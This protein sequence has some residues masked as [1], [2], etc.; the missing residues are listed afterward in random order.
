MSKNIKQPWFR[1]H[2]ELL[3]DVEHALKHYKWLRLVVKEDVVYVKGTLLVVN[4]R[5]SIEISFP[6]DYPNT[7]PVVRETGGKIP[8]LVD[9]HVNENN[10]TAC[11]CV[12][13][14]WF[15]D[16]TDSSF[17]TFLKIPVN[18]YFLSQQH[19]E[20]HKKWPFDERKHG[21]EGI[22][23][24]YKEHFATD[25]LDVIKKYL[26]YLSQNTIKGHW[27]CPC[28]SGK[29]LRKCHNLKI[30]KMKEKLPASAASKSLQSLFGS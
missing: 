7:L 3:Q 15:I 16:R 21:K 19:Y 28:G 4:E 10:G 26:E 9:R 18:N 25:D 13:D 22:L 2:P 17:A 27:D 24:F 23:D 14:E 1:Q 29:K 8:R 11:V 12:P 6:P 30:R 5:Y 20:I